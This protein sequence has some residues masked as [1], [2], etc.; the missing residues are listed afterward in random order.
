MDEV[1]LPRGSTT[2]ESNI[3]LRRISLLI[4][5]DITLLSGYGIIKE[6]CVLIVL[7]ITKNRKPLMRASPRMS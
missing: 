3:T 5:L 1:L 2:K 7:T 6:S 4:N